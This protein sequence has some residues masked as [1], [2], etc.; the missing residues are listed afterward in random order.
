MYM[1]M[2][3][4]TVHS[5]PYMGIITPPTGVMHMYV[6]SVFSPITN[7]VEPSTLSAHP[8]TDGVQSFSDNIHVHVHV[9]YSRC[10]L[11]A[12]AVWWLRGCSKGLWK[13]LHGH[14]AHVHVHVRTCL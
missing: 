2:Y 12:L 1:Y 11:T 7:I 5:H 9:Q 10:P 6:Y 4:Y 13:T 14:T 3:M 8:I